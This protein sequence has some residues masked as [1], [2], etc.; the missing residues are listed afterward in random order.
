MNK[1]TLDRFLERNKNIG[2][3]VVYDIGANRGDWTQEY[4]KNLNSN[5]EYYLFEANEFYESVLKQNNK[6]YYIVLLSNEEKIIE[7]YSNNSTGDSYYKEITGNYENIKPKLLKSKTLDSFC[8]ENK[9]PNPDLI[10]IDTQGSEIDIL[11]GGINVLSKCKMVLLEVPILEYNAGAPKIQEYLDFMNNNGFVP[12]YI[13]QCYFLNG[14]LMQVD[15]IFA[16]KN[17]VHNIFTSV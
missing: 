2:I 8:L 12:S 15:M 17:I 11:L 10:K 4:S 9:I 13:S 7:F 1:P 16:N 5:T 6:N 3:Q 14:K